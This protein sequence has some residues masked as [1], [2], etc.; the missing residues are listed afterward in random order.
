[1][2]EVT[3]RTSESIF[4]GIPR[5]GNRPVHLLCW[6]VPQLGFTGKNLVN[7]ISFDHLSVLPNWLE[8]E[9]M[10]PV[11]PKLYAV[12]KVGLTVLFP[13]IPWCSLCHEVACRHGKDPVFMP[14]WTTETPILNNPDFW[15]HIP[16]G[17]Q[18]VDCT[19]FAT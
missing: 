7:G 2:C 11:S 15:C 16:E 19:T 8:C 17:L 1:M 12:G 6:E 13:N 18:Y 5:Y 3:L 14:T 10:L 9:V 4:H